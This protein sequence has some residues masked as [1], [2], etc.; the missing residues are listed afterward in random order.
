MV[1]IR[2]GVWRESGRMH[3]IYYFREDFQKE[4]LGVSVFHSRF[5]VYLVGR[6]PS[7]FIRIWFQQSRHCLAGFEEKAFL[8]CVRREMRPI[9]DEIVQSKMYASLSIWW[10]LSWRNNIVTYKPTSYIYY[11]IVSTILIS[12]KVFYAL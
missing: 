5:T 12:K 7:S 8:L 4:I 11:F 1:F 10:A 9:W 6:L 2:L 3:S